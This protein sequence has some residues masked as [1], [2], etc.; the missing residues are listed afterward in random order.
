VSAG[1]PQAGAPIEV[2]VMAKHPAP[3]QVKSRL[4][5]AIGAEAAAD[6]YRAFVLDLAERL[7][8]AGIEPLWAVWPAGAPF[9]T[10]LP[11][12]GRCDQ[13]GRD[14]GERMAG[15]AR[16]VLNGGAAGV[17]F[18]G[19]DVP[20]V[21]VDEVRAA[22]QTLR[23]RAHDVVLG[24]ADDGGYYLLGLR[25]FI[26]P[27]FQDI[28]WGGPRVLASTTTRLAELNVA[29]RTM[30]PC[31]DVDEQADLLRLAALV[32]RGTVVLPHTAAALARAGL[33]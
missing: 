12:A 4:A 27:L 16:R 33:S 20:H 21:D 32:R 2:V 7:H 25:R 22:M 28:E 23:E 29:Y 19:A 3:G 14:L 9:E 11:G 10:V 6:L 24:P 17:V 8:D 26:G 31:F 13:E 5:A 1:G 18:L 15:V 30:A